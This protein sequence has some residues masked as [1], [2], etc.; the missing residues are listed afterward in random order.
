M[1]RVK[2]PVNIR[3]SRSD[4]SAPSAKGEEKREQAK[5]VSHRDSL[6]QVS[7]RERLPPLPHRNLA[8]EDVFAT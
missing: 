3:S 1:S 7:L 4:E 2:G 8:Y 6:R 5:P